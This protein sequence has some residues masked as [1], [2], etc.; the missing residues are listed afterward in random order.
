MNK[1]LL[2]DS[3][4][5]QLI[6]SDTDVSRTLKH[7]KGKCA[8]LSTTKKVFIIILIIETL[9]LIA[10]EIQLYTFEKN[11]NLRGTVIIAM[12]LSVGVTMLAIDSVL[13][14]NKFEF[15]VFLV[16]STL[17][18]GYSG[19]QFYTMGSDRLTAVPLARF[20]V[21]ICFGV[22]NYI[23]G[24]IVYQDFGW[25]MYRKIGAD[26][27]LVSMYKN[28]QIFV[29]LLKMD[30]LFNIVGVCSFGLFLFEDWEWIILIVSLLVTFGW[31]IL[32]WLGSRKENKLAFI[33]FFLFS[34]VEPVYIISRAAYVII[35][36]QSNKRETWPSLIAI[37]VCSLIVR[38]LLIIYAIFVRLHFGGGLK[39]DIFDKEDRLPFFTA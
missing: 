24:Y 6:N 9:A 3:E 7:P 31:I 27:N 22:I 30:F 39:E 15:A 37:V 26:F 16:T 21:S 28:Y 38:S 10:F 36:H 32:G 12:I 29:S 19:F 1:S 11:I 13:V 35:K 8:K 23:L 17:V 25:R 4:N 34:L 14:E 5:D 33:F 2:S 18:M 20:I